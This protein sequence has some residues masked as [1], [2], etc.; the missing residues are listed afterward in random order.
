MAISSFLVLG[1]GYGIENREEDKAMKVICNH[2][3]VE[4]TLWP[5]YDIY[6]L[7]VSL[8]SWRNTGHIVP[9]KCT[10]NTWKKGLFLTFWP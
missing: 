10:Y 8:F 1:M 7:Y 2:H 3:A 5:Y 4:G 6:P 9:L